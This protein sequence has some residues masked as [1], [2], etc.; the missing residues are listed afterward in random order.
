MHVN[1]RWKWGLSVSY[2][3]GFFIATWCHK[4]YNLFTWFVFC[5]LSSIF[6]TIL[7]LCII[8]FNTLKL[9]VGRR[10]AFFLPRHVT[11]MFLVFEC[12]YYNLHLGSVLPWQQLC[13]TTLMWDSWTVFVSLARPVLA[14]NTARQREG[15]SDKERKKE[16]SL[17]KSMWYRFLP[18]DAN[19]CPFFPLQLSDLNLR[20]Q[21]PQQA[22]LY[23]ALVTL[24]SLCLTPKWQSVWVL[25][26]KVG[27]KVFQIRI[28]EASHR[29]TCFI[30]FSIM[31]KWAS[32]GDHP[33][34]LTFS[35]TDTSSG[36]NVSCLWNTVSSPPF[37]FFFSL[38]PSM[39]V[40]RSEFPLRWGLD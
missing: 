34:R 19:W 17:L 1:T 6:T 2:V 37:F 7:F 25:A 4:I 9:H 3:M 32:P 30:H 27:E 10:V 16:M 22:L 31:C 24:S 18:K 29:D 40:S 33:L 39:H 38:T 14:R 5:G 15:N 26:D 28:Y 35:S 20:L 23:G 13:L 36:Y 21:P 12:S 11:S 8:I